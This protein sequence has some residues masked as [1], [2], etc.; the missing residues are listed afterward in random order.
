M[1]DKRA[2]PT[3]VKRVGRWVRSRSVSA[4][5]TMGVVAAL[6]LLVLLRA[7]VKKHSHFFVATQVAHSAGLLILI[8]KLSVTKTCSGTSFFLPLS[9][10]FFSINGIDFRLKMN[11]LHQTSY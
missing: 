4:K 7:F 1:G 6:V 9:R 11:G 8:Y 3:P 10:N 5:V 2:A